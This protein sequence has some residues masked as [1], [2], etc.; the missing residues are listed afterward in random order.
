[1]ADDENEN[2]EEQDEDLLTSKAA[3]GS[4]GDADSILNYALNEFNKN[5]KVVLRHVPMATTVSL[6]KTRLIEP[7][8]LPTCAVN[9]FSPAL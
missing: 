7:Y 6:R 2:H 9:D 3:G 5:R 4:L 8:P 1:M